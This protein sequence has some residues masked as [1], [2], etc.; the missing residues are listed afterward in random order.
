MMRCVLGRSRGGINRKEPT[1]PD[2]TVARN[3]RPETPIRPACTKEIC[4]K[5]QSEGQPP[6]DCLYHRCDARFQRL[7]LSNYTGRSPKKKPADGSI[8]TAGVLMPPLP[9]DRSGSS[10]SIDD[11]DAENAATR[12][13]GKPSGSLSLGGLVLRPFLRRFSKL[14]R[15][16]EIRRLTGVLGRDEGGGG[17]APLPLTLLLLLMS[18]G[19]GG[20]GGRGAIAPNVAWGMFDHGAMGEGCGPAAAPLV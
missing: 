16:I 13:G 7:K 8:V 18:F 14:L 4:V 12:P 11:E 6:R 15:P 19:V 20:R 2:Q 1:G 17:R 5:I 10:K 3:P 9:C